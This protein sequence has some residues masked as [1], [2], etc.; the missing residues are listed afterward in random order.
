[1][2]LDRDAYAEASADPK[3]REIE[4]GIIMRPFH[5]G[6][7]TMPQEWH[8]YCATHQDFG[9]CGIESAAFAAGHAHGR[10]H[11]L[12]SSVPKED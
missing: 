5:V 10:K 8:V 11:A 6:Y 9:F 2:M 1:M 3:M 7:T 4:A 12:A